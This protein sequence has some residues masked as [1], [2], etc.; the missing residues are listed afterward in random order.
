MEAVRQS[1][2]DDRLDHLNHKVDE[3]F[4]LV[5]ERFRRVDQ[6]FEQVDQRF[7][8][9]ETSIRDLRVEMDLRFGRLEE[10]I[11]RLQQTIMVVGGGLFGTVVI[12]FSGLIATQL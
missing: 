10:K 7:E 6:R 8:R 5:D 1:W 11:D 2:S 4:R 9:V 3:G 12:A